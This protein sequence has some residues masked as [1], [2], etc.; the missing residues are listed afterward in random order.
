VSVCGVVRGSKGPFEMQ[1]LPALRTHAAKLNTHPGASR[2]G[3]P[4]SPVGAPPRGSSLSA[5]TAEVIYGCSY[6]DEADLLDMQ[7][8]IEK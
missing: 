6:R 3:A 5:V 8:A 7:T 2:V 1:A 4:T